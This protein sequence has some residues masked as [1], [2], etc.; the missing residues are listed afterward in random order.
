MHN[1]S[2]L[3]EQ[4]TVLQSEKQ[5]AF[6]NKEPKEA[7]HE[8]QQKIN[9]LSI[10]IRTYNFDETPTKLLSEPENIV[11]A[12]CSA[13]LPKPAIIP[14]SYD[15]FVKYKH[16]SII[17][18]ITAQLTSIEV[19]IGV[20]AIFKNTVVQSDEYIMKHHYNIYCSKVES[21]NNE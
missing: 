18:Y 21:K 14:L 2:D 6:L 4:R 13:V 17:S 1:Y 8:L 16:D 5:L 19:P 10:L 9:I 3:L 11:T 20:Y 7:I 12:D 15:D